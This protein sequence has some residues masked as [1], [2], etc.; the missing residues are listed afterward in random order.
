MHVYHLTTKYE[1]Q[2]LTRKPRIPT[3]RAYN[4]DAITSRVCCAPDIEGC[5][6]ALQFEF[7]EEGNPD[8]KYSNLYRHYIYRTDIESFYQPSSQEVPDVEDTLEIWILEPVTFDY[9]GAID[10]DAQG[11]YR[12]VEKMA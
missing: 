4:E 8:F 6:L 12:F 2:K 10:I 7:P 1:L 5:L 3:T 11:A 9:I